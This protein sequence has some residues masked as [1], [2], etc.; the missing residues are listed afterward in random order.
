MTGES[1]EIGEGFDLE[2]AIKLMV[3]SLEILDRSGVP[4]DIGAHLDLAIVR[5]LGHLGRLD[6]QSAIM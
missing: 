6:S 1:T 4:S 2:L 5:L 3:R